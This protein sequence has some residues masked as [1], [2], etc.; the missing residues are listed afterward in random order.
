[1]PGLFRFRIMYDGIRYWLWPQFVLKGVTTPIEHFDIRLML[2]E[3]DLR[4]SRENYIQYRNDGA[5]YY[6][7]GQ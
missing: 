2:P 7:S 6:R 1:M 3:M 4:L 5:R